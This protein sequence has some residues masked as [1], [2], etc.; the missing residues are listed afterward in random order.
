MILNP[1]VQSKAQ[2][3]LDRVVGPNRLP[4]FSDE[5]DLPYLR[6]IC[7]EVL[8][9]EPVLPLGLPHRNI[10]DDEYR[11][12]FIPKGST[13]LVNQWSV[14]QQPRAGVIV[15]ERPNKGPCSEMRKNLDTRP[16]NFD[17]SDF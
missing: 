8:R 10:R 14:C 1:E 9:W 11:G 5:S 17:L 15:V 4:E 2:E 12:M 16:R 6:A 7:K 3:E 13:I